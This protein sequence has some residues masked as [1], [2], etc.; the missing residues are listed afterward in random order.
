MCT[1]CEGSVSFLTL[2]S[3]EEEVNIFYED[4]SNQPI[5]DDTL[6]RLLTFPN[7]LITAHQAF[8]TAACLKQIAHATLQNATQFSSVTTK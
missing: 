8:F 6:A 5:Q 7:V 4:M 3:Y 2:S 1:S